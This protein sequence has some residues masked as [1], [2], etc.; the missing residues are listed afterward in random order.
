M[1][2]CKSVSR[3]WTASRFKYNCEPNFGKVKVGRSFKRRNLETNVEDGFLRIFEKR[4]VIKLKGNEEN[5][6][7]SIAL[8]AIHNFDT[9]FF[10]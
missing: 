5:V 1:Y 2:V 9:V 10:R 6:S 4:Q 3:S 7:V 8:Y